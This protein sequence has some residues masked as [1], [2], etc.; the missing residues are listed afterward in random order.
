[1]SWLFLLQLPWEHRAADTCT[2]ACFSPALPPSSAGPGA[3]SCVS[4]R[5]RQPRWQELWSMEKRAP[6]SQ[7]CCGITGDSGLPGP[8]AVAPQGRPQLPINPIH[9]AQWA[10][11]DKAQLLYPC[12]RFQRI[13][14]SVL[15][16][17]VVASSLGSPDQWLVGT[18]ALPLSGLGNDLTLEPR[19]SPGVP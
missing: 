18:L 10:F 16:L 7:G 1:M 15:L 5:L 12:R 3:P 11:D 17:Q 9:G 4:S 8:V 19:A 2:R 14:N 13:Q 6:L